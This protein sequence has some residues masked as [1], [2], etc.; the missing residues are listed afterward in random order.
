MKIQLFQ[1]QQDDE[2]RLAR[3]AHADSQGVSMD[4]DRVKQAEQALEREKQ[5]HN[6]TKVRFTATII[7]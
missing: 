4:A 2:K 3:A 6:A 5:K 1:L 7:R